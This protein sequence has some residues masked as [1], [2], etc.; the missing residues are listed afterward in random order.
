[1]RI[2]PFT[3][4]AFEMQLITLDWQVYIDGLSPSIKLLPPEEKRRFMHNRSINKKYNKILIDVLR[5]KAK[6]SKITTIY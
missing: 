1:P 2:Y 6:K 3:A 4:L 5:K